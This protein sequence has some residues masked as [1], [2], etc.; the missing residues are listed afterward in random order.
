[1]RRMF[2]GHSCR[3][4]AS[5]RPD[6]HVLAV[7]VTRRS[8]VRS[9]RS[10]PLPVQV[11]RPLQIEP[12][13]CMHTERGFRRQPGGSSTWPRSLCSTTQAAISTR[14]EKPSFSRMRETWVATVAGLR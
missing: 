14:D 13:P 10:L 7:Q 9:T 5:R 4:S 8:R 6:T 2:I 1:M 3:D 11:P 12:A